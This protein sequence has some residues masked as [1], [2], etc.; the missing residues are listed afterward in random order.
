MIM[1]EHSIETMI[2][3][4]THFGLN[5]YEAKCYIALIQNGQS[6]GYQISKTSTVPRARIY[7]TLTKLIEKG[8]VFKHEAEQTTYTALDYSELLQKFQTQYNDVIRS[9]E[10]Q[11][12]ALPKT[13]NETLLIQTFHQEMHIK[14]KI[15]EIIKNAKTIY[16]SC[17]PAIYKC[18]SE[19]I[20]ACNPNIEVKGIV[21]EETASYEHVI[22]H[23]QTTYTNNLHNEKWFI[24]I[25]NQNEMLY[26]NDLSVKSLAYYTQDP[27]QIYL[28]KN[29]IWH[30]ILVNE[31]VKN[32]NQDEDE[33]IKSKRETF[34]K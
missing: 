3:Q 18:I 27:T 26:G 5:T 2:Q 12:E 8:I 16:I 6:N 21:F 23:R 28:L 25:N 7:D 17:F 1:S 29:F 4:L 13:Q 11:F 30:D 33:W 15:E 31:F 32:S 22:T 10:T 24:L 14:D 9:L 34:F 19:K 20:A